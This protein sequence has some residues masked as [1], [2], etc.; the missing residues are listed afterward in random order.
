MSDDTT[1]PTPERSH[2][3]EETPGKMHNFSGYIHVGPGAEECE[4]IVTITDKRG[5]ESRVPNGK[6][7]DNDHFHAWVRMPNQFERKSI[8]DKA[9]AAEARRLRAFRDPESGESLVLDNEVEMLVIRGERE[10]LID[11]IVGSDFFQDHLRAVKEVAEEDEKE[12]GEWATIEEDR[13]RLNSLRDRAPEDRNEEE[14]AELG[15][16][17]ARHA[18]IVNARRDEIQA[19]R[20]QALTETP[21]ADLGTMVRQLRVDAMAS[22]TSREEKLKWEMYICTLRP[23]NPEKPGFP[24]ERCFSSIDTFVAAAPEVL[25]AIAQTVTRLNQEAG[26]HLKG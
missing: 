13:E 7:D 15:E 19:P 23:K 10:E 24:S 22:G 1:T 18:E 4:S 3:E 21:L 14:Y 17:I 20:R 16:R 12:D 2:A 25:E 8:I 5:V 6:C 26:G 11:E 9:A